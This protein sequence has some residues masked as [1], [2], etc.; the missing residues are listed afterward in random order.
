MEEA[1]G[2]HITIQTGKSQAQ[3]AKAKDIHARRAAA[4]GTPS[5][6]DIQSGEGSDSKGSGTKG[7]DSDRGSD[8]RGDTIMTDMV[9]Y[10]LGA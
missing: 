2:R 4:A 9:G 7:E 5:A 6:H 10:L 3:S 8:D 1:I